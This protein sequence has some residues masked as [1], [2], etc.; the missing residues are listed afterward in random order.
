MR[1]STYSDYALRMLMYLG[2]KRDGLATIAEVAA[3][4]RVSK[5]HLMKVAYE[6]GQA[7]FVETV[8]G[9]NGGLRLARPPEEIR[10]GAVLRFTEADSALVGCFAN[11]QEDPCPLVPACVL[12]GALNEALQAFFA[13]LDDYTLAD[14]VKPRRSLSELLGLPAG[15]K[16]LPAAEPV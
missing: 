10:I 12:K 13:T 3:R 4:Y 2:L 1:L 9:R 8:R 14:M 15:V 6:L 16:P 11:T 5:N 7:G